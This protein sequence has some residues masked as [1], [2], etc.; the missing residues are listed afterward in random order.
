MT[1]D[2]WRLTVFDILL[3]RDLDEISGDEPGFQRFG[4]YSKA[5]AGVGFTAET[6]RF[7]TDTEE[8]SEHYTTVTG[9]PFTTLG[10][11]FDQDAMR[12]ALAARSP[13]TADDPLIVGYLGDA[14]PEKGYQFLPDLAERLTPSHLSNGKARLR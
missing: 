7:F 5:F 12:T 1:R 9:V 11:A 4:A 10:I 14:R 8:L 2:R 6:V 3:R 13:K